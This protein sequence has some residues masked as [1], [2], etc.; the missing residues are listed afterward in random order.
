MHR[1][2]NT[3]MISFRE[4][5]GSQVIDDAIQKAFQQAPQMADGIDNGY[6][7]YYTVN[8][9]INGDSEQF[10]HI[11]DKRIRKMSTAP[12]FPFY[13]SDMKVQYGGDR[14]GMKFYVLGMLRGEVSPRAYLTP[15]GV[16]K[17]PLQVTSSGM[18]N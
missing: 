18:E 17:M 8:V 9:P 4:W 6:N 7:H 1:L 15:K 5:Y 11:I 2:L 16:Q 10:K 3:W 12:D 13:P 14:G